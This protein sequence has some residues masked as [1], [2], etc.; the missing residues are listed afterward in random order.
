MRRLLTLVVVSILLIPFVSVQGEEQGPL[1][2]A[3]SAGG[4]DYE[5]LAGHVVLDDNSII[6]AGQYTSSATFGDDGIGATGFE[7]DEDIFVATMNSLG[8]WTS[9]QGFGS[10]G[11]DGIDAI[12]LHGSGDIILAGHFCLGTAGES[13]EMDMGTQTLVKGNEQGEG[14]AFVGRFSF[15]AGQLNIIWIR[16][17]S[18]DNDLSALD[19]SIS[20]SGGI[21]VGIFHR[22]VIEVE[23]QI[24]PGAGGLSLAI[25]HYDENG[26][27]VWVNGISSPND[28]EPF[29]G[30]CYS[31]S[32]YLHVTGTFIGAIMFIET[33]DSEGGADIFAAQLDGD[34]NFTWTSFAGSTGD[35]LDSHISIPDNSSNPFHLY[36][37]EDSYV[38][39][40][41]DNTT[42][43]WD[44]SDGAPGTE[45]ITITH[46]KSGDY[47]YSVHDYSNK[48]LTSPDII[49]KSG[50]WYAYGDTKLGQGRDSVKE[51][52]G[53]NPELFEELESKI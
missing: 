44:D 36:Y 18:N 2:W 26:D 19:I 46:V 43:D 47:S 27:L 16:T 38:Y 41:N 10:T 3:Q 28:L 35:D 32:G 8:N 52:L 25:L 50:S 24:V 4:F 49:S 11:A 13:C 42:L 39:G 53:D 23:D 14:D 7:G 48:A 37:G 45:T 34:G 29:G 21:S 22:D 20:P 9:I 5:T 31:D 33:Y 6:V 15:D 12:A 30:M 1:G 17:I 40:T 51:I